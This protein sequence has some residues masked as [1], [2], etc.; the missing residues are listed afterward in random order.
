MSCT[1]FEIL[2][3]WHC[4]GLSIV[5]SYSMK[6]ASCSILS[7]VYNSRNGFGIYNIFCAFEAT[8]VMC[9]GF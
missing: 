4:F 7:P 9:V 8:K 5:L 6:Y 1:A 3:G 2:F